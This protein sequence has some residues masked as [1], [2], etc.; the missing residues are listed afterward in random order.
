M[1]ANPVLLDFPDTIETERLLIR[2]PR[3]GDGPAFNAA[4]LDSLDGINTW[5]G[6]YRDGPPSVDDSESLMRREHAKFMARENLMLLIFLKHDG[7]LVAASGLHPRWN[8]PMFE[9]G[10]WCR[11]P[12]SGHGYVTEAVSAETEFAFTYLKACR[13]YIRCDTKNAAS[14][15]VARR[16]GFTLEATLHWDS[17]GPDGALRDTHV[18]ALTRP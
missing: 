12:Y 14:A 17:R 13:V 6:F 1:I 10:Y 3:P 8:V 15:A 18:F 16:A 2:G 7:T 5:L 9:I 11:T 4:I